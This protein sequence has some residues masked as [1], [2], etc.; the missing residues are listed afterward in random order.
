MN[1]TPSIFVAG[2]GFMGSG[3]AQTIAACGNAV[4]VYDL[5]KERLEK[6]RQEILWSVDKI[7]SKDPSLCPDS[8]A[9]IEK[10]TFT[11]ELEIAKHAE[12]VIEAVVEHF[13]TKVDLF[14]KLEG[15]CPSKTLFFSNTS[16]IPIG[17]LAVVLRQPSRIC[18]MHFFAPVPL[19]KLVEVIRADETS[20]A[21]AMK[22]MELA[23]A[24]GK[25]PVLVR[26]D[27]PGFIVNRLLIVMAFEAIRM[28]EAGVATAAD[29]DQAMKLGCSHRMGPLETMDLSGLD[30]FLDAGETIYQETSDPKFQPPPLLRQMVKEGRLGRKSGRGFLCGEDNQTDS[31]K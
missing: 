24:W 29:I 15:I 12:V 4:A 17:R 5:S 16:A 20:D 6:S 30:I 18:G 10:I 2:A 14:C 19:M 3:I 28:L 7:H 9:V 25:S 21:T 1:D 11:T 23:A 22:A 13:E 26:R 31:R 8:K 27:A